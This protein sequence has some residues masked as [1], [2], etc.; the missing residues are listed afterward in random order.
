MIIKVNMIN[1]P[2]EMSCTV[3][4]EVTDYDFNLIYLFLTKY[5]LDWESKHQKD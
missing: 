1:Q 3:I 2:V 5:Q 4:W